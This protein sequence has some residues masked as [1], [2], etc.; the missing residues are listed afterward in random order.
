MKTLTFLLILS[1]FIISTSATADGYVQRSISEA[2][3]N[4]TLSSMLT[5]AVEE[6][7]QQI[8]ASRLT[9]ENV[10]AV[11]SSVQFVEDSATPNQ[12]KA[13]LSVIYDLQ[14]ADTR[15]VLK[16]ILTVVKPWD[17]NNKKLVSSQ[18]YN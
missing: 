11:S 12:L 7:R 15:K 13:G 4:T 16:V 2:T 17:S 9:L 14:L 6:Y 5:F 18:Q 8:R 3:G 1:I 10:N